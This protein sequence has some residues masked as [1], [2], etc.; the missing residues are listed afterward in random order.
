M[1]GYLAKEGE[2]KVDGM[3]R[4]QLTVASKEFEN[5]LNELRRGPP[6]MV[7]TNKNFSEFVEM[8]DL[9]GSEDINSFGDYLQ[10]PL[11]SSEDSE[12]DDFQTPLN[13]P[14]KATTVVSDSNH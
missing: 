11:P 7:T 12:K 6:G 5:G 10:V 9:D 2:A 1:L 8:D 3:T 13:S 14:N 4:A